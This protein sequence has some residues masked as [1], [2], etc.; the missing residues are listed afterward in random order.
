MRSVLISNGILQNAYFVPGLLS[1]YKKFTAAH[2][3][4]MVK[5]SPIEKAF[6][7]GIKECK[8]YQCGEK[9]LGI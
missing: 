9:E 5:T 7:F 6:V 3:F 1:L 4:Y 8:V 2:L